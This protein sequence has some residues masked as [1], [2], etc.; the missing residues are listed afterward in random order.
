MK[1]DTPKKEYI[2]CGIDGKQSKPLQLNKSQ[3]DFAVWVT[4]NFNTLD[5]ALKADAECTEKLLKEKEEA[6][7]QEQ[8]RIA[9]EQRIK[10]ER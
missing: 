3:Y 9:E 4:E 6:E 7:R 2:F 1:Y 5:D 10:A 8:K